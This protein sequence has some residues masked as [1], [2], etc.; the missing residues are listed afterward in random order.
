MELR[1]PEVDCDLREWA[2]SLFAQVGISGNV[3]VAQKFE[4]QILIYSVSPAP[5]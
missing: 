2:C 1:V 4:K 3:C 5:F